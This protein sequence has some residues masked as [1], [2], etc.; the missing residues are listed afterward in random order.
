MFNWERIGKS[1]LQETKKSREDINGILEKIEFLASEC[2]EITSNRRMLN[3]IGKILII[4]NSITVLVPCC[5]TLKSGSK[6][7]VERHLTFLQK[8]SKIIPSIIPLFL[9][10]DHE[11]EDASLCSAIGKTQEE[12]RLMALQSLRDIALIIKPFNWK[13]ALMSETIQNLIQCENETAQWIAGE[14][15]FK[16]RLITEMVAR[17]NLYNNIYQA[18]QMTIEGKMKRTIKT[19]AQ[20]VVMG[21]FADKNNFLICNHTTSNLTWY[22]QTKAAILHNQIIPY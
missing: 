9:V 10:A 8:V 19:A 4:Q 18:K 14:K 6:I 15:Q 7:L 12:F 17:E 2:G 11:S 22:L 3:R 16:A 20:Y 5:Q 1:L 13:V 21:N